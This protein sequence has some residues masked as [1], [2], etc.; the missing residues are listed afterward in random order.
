MVAKQQHTSPDVFL[1]HPGETIY[2]VIQDRNISQKEL[3]I[4]TGYTEKHISTIING[5]K[6]ISAEFAKKLEYALNIPASFW[7]NLQTNYDLEV[8]EFNEKHS[9]TEKESQIAKEIKQTVELITGKSFKSNQGIGPVYE[10]RKFLGV[11]NLCS[12]LTLN[13]PRFRAKFQ[14]NTSEHIMSTWQYLCGKK[15]ENQTDAPLNIGKLIQSIDEI[16]QI[17]HE[18]DST[19][20]KKM[21]QEVLNRSGVLFTVEKHGKNTPINGLTA[22]TKNNQVMI[23][24]TLRLKYVDVFW[25]TLFHEIGHVIAKD[26]LRDQSIW[27]E[28]DKIEER[29]NKFAADVLIDSQKYKIFIARKDFSNSAI[30]NFA[31]ENNVLPTIV[32]G[33]LMHDGIKPWYSFNRD[34]YEWIR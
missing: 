22:K 5:Q 6:N 11:S 2:E 23:A 26:Y 10:M 20:H 29:A 34:T 4:R 7:R 17:M 9:I 13:P 19:K 24:L 32:Y 8:V 12:I 21:I 14:K 31:K 18:P 27:D 33:R 30:E 1:I 28:I 15:V 25:F 16:K 3:A